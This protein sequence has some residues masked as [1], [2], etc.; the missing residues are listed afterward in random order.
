M[1]I[2]KIGFTRADF[3]INERKVMKILGKLA[4]KIRVFAAGRGYVCDCCGG[5]IFEYPSR[6]FCA[7]CQEKMRLNNRFTCQ[8]CGRKTM[9]QG[10]CLLCKEELPKFSKGIS[11]FVYEKESAALINRVKNGKRRLAYYFAEAMADRLMAEYKE[12]MAIERFLI[13]A[14]PMTSARE[15]ERGFNQSI[16]LAEIIAT[17]LEKK[18]VEADL[19]CEILQKR[20]DSTPQKRMDFRE[21]RENVKGAY[22]VH[23]RKECH[24]R[25]IVLIDDIMTTGATGSE[26]AAR[27]LGAGAKEVIFLVA[28]ALPER[29]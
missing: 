23:K 18:G 12:R 10:V 4:Q 20:I 16:E 3:F 6:R 8:K 13:T 24:D 7:D 27:L 14:V 2:R 5:E 1:R 28:A 22:H 19:D 21:R 15:K 26:C 29:I 9:T 25:T 11:P 17:T